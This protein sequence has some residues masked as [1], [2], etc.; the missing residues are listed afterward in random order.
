VRATRQVALAAVCC[1]AILAAAFAFLSMRYA[2]GRLR[3]LP[4]DEVYPSAELAMRHL[5]DATYPSARV[6]I[7][8]NGV[9]GP[10]LRYVV[11]R[12]WQSKGGQRTTSD[13]IEQGCY[14]LLMENGWVHLAADEFSGPTVAVGKFLLERL[15]SGTRRSPA[16]SGSGK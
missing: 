10:G 15:G 12:V 9:D 16:G 6:E 11:A 14:F 8:G 3:A 2:A 7:V 4:D 5:M 1:A 13:P